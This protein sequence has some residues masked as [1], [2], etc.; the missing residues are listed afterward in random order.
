MS[1]PPAVTAR[2]HPE[3]AAVV[4]AAGS[5]CLQGI[6][7]HAAIDEMPETEADDPDGEGDQIPRRFAGELQR[8]ER[9]AALMALRRVAERAAGVVA[10]GGD[11]LR[12]SYWSTSRQ[13]ASPA[14][15]PPR[16]E[17]IT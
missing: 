11:R 17:V 3:L 12:T 7:Q 2:K 13:A 14:R 15:A 8:V 16:A 4:S 10:G 6:A 5:D 9:A 1:Q